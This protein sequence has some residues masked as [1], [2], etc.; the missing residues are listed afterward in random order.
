MSDLHQNIKK[1]FFFHQQINRLYTNQ[2]EGLLK[3]NSYGK[4]QL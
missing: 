1:I 3:N 4:V 2:I